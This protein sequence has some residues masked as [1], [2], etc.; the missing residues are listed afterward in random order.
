L[1]LHSTIYKIRK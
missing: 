1:K